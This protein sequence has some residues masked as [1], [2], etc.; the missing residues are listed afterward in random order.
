MHSVTEGQTDGRQGDA[1]GR[2]Y[3]IAVRLAKH[4]KKIPKKRSFLRALIWILIE[5]TAARS[6]DGVNR[7]SKDVTVR[8]SS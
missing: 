8:G 3:C 1:N 6:I 2:S 4:L 7:K 5:Q